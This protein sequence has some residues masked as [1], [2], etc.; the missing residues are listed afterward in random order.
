VFQQ[1]FVLV[2]IGYLIV[3]DNLVQAKLLEFL[4][5]SHAFSRQ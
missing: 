4:K 3:A 2:H 5:E 1:F